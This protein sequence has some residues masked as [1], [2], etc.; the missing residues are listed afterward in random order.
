MRYTKLNFSV[1]LLTFGLKVGNLRK[2]RRS[3]A[4][5]LAGAVHV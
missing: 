1:T 5:V 4:I 2:L 3:Q